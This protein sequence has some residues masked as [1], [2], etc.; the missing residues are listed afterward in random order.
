[1]QNENKR[2]FARDNF[3]RVRSAVM[4]AKGRMK[5]PFYQKL[6]NGNENLRENKSRSRFSGLHMSL[7]SLCS[8]QSRSRFQLS[9]NES[10]NLKQDEKSD[11]ESE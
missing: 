2:R 7:Q 10:S 8:F 1:M 5:T 6:Q 11:V 9:R 4:T 3:P